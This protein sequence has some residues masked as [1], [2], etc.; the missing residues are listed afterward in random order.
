MLPILG[1]R[2]AEN[3]PSE[4]CDTLDV[5]VIGPPQENR[6]G[7]IEGLKHYSI[8]S[9]DGDYVYEDPGRVT[10]FQWTRSKGA[11]AYPYLIASLSHR[12]VSRARGALVAPK[13]LYGNQEVGGKL[14]NLIESSRAEFEQLW[15]EILG[16]SEDEV[17]WARRQLQCYRR[18][19]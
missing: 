17:D 4:K 2:P 1:C 14:R 8:A 16:I 9:Y 7:M 19:R 10:A 12:D 6:D 13:V 5:L 3:E 15:R 18:D 11:A